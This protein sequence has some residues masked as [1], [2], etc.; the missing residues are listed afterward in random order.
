MADISSVIAEVIWR[1]TEMRAK[2][3]RAN[4]GDKFLGR[5]RV[6]SPRITWVQVERETE[7]GPR[8]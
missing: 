7:A 4:L 1:Q 3:R 2:D 5:Q 6:W 8:Q